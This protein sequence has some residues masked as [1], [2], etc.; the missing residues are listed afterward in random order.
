M[1][2]RPNVETAR[3]SE[4]SFLAVSALTQAVQKATNDNNL[5]IQNKWPNDLLISGKKIAGILLESSI[6]HQKVE[7]VVIGVGLNLVSNPSGANARYEASNLKLSG[8]KLSA[9]KAL[10]LFL[11]EFE[12]LYQNWLSFGFTK[13]RNLW[14]ANAYGL[15]EQIKLSSGLEGIFTDLDEQGNLILELLNNSKIKISADE[16]NSQTAS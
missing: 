14:L 7:F 4:L 12:N 2:L 1:A 9:C 15:G 10:E 16:I 11:T 3:I 6:S 5:L 8:V 13:V